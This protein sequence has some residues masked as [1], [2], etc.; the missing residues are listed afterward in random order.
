MPEQSGNRG[1]LSLAEASRIQHELAARVSTKGFPA[2]IN[3]V[4]GF[5]ISYQLNQN[6]LIAGIVLFAFPSLEVIS[7]HFYTDTIQFPYIPGYLSFREAPALLHL[8]KEYGSGADIFI[9]DGHGIAHPRGLGIAAHIGVLTGKP[10]IGCAKKK[11]VGQYREPGNDRGASSIL[12]YKEQDVGRV[13]RTRSST[14]PVFI[15]IGNRC[16]IDSAVRLIMD[17][18]TKYRI[19]EPTRIAHNFVTAYKKEILR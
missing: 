8:I 14:K 1:D 11:L 19:P 15:S 13:I 18:T 10:A 9:F 3:T 5:D 7:H 16:D 12:Y 2:T 17:C 4:A 6:R